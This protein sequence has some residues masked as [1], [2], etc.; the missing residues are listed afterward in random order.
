MSD[1]SLQKT[2]FGAIYDQADPRAYFRRLQP[3][4]YVIPQYGA[5]AFSNLL[6]TVH[7][8]GRPPNVLDVASSY[9]IVG[10]LLRTDLRLTDLYKHYTAAPTVT[11]S[12]D[13]LR[14]TD[15][16]L[17]ADHRISTAPRVVGLDVAKLK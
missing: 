1:Q 3:Y 8:G 9:G 14:E 12:P 10:T 15:R 17:L 2:D 16:R 11:H 5:D 4:K 6:D 13:V 7:R